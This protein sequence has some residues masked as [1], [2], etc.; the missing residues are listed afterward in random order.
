MPPY[1]LSPTV[2]EAAAIYVLIVYFILTPLSIIIG[3]AGI[4]TTG[5]LH[6]RTT[7][8]NNLYLILTEAALSLILLINIYFCAYFII[9]I[10]T[11][12][13]KQDSNIKYYSIVYIVLDI[14]ACAVGIGA[15]SIRPS[16]LSRNNDRRLNDAVFGLLCTMVVIQGIC[17]FGQFISVLNDFE[18]IQIWT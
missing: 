15:L 13:K 2:N 3:I 1:I 17:L 11:D 6:S 18:I 8:K 4:I 7:P 12:V 10:A 9:L 16:D 14:I 5:I